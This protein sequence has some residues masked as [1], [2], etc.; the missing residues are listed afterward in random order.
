MKVQLNEYFFAEQTLATIVETIL[1]RL[2]Y[3]VIL[4]GSLDIHCL[5][6]KTFFSVSQSNI[7]KKNSFGWE[8]CTGKRKKK[9]V[10]LLF[11]KEFLSLSLSKFRKLEE[12]VV[13]IFD[14][15]TVKQSKIWHKKKLK[16]KVFATKTFQ[17]NW[18][19]KFFEFL[20]KQN[21]DVDWDQWKWYKI[22]P[23]NTIWYHMISNKIFCFFRNDVS[24][25]VLTEMVM[26]DLNS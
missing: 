10:L 2:Y 22:I 6:E 12:K 3:K 26:H 19:K 17:R 21:S 8:K 15:W 25:F 14:P 20:L 5:L 7:F 24:Y 16:S 9:K 23:Y 1:E 18:K 4:E 11:E 13:E